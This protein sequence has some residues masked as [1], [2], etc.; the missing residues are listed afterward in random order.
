M[1]RYIYKPILLVLV[2]LSSLIICC[3]RPDVPKPVEYKG[4]LR[5]AEDIEVL[6]TEKDQMK[7]KMKAKKI[8]EFQNG[9]I[10]LPEGMFL[11][12][13]DDT[14]KLASTLKADSAY[15]FKEEDKWRT[16]GHVEVINLEKEE[17]LTTEELF[18]KPTTKK[19]FTEKFF[20]LKEPTRTITGIKLQANQDLSEYSFENTAADL[21]IE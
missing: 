3:K 20:T 1:A 2:T 11:E 8:L 5:E 15:Y 19:I 13:Y 16:R 4:A 17:H 9:D 6:S 10:E 7:S 12:T 21:E 14:G 18:W